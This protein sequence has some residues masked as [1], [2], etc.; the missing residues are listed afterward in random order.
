MCATR[1]SRYTARNDSGHETKQRRKP[2][3]IISSRFPPNDEKRMYSIVH[4]LY[5]ID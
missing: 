4:L 3:P 2:K 1:A 5:K